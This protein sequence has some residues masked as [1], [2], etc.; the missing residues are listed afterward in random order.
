MKKKT[1]LLLI[2]GMILI[3]FLAIFKEKDIMPN[4]SSPSSN[5]FKKKDSNKETPI[6]KKIKK[7][8]MNDSVINSDMIF[9]IVS[10]NLSKELQQ[11][12]K[13]D[14]ATYVINEANV[15]ENKKFLDENNYLQVEMTIE[16]K[17]N[18]SKD[19]YL[20]NYQVLSE[21]GELRL[22]ASLTSTKTDADPQS[23]SNF[24]FTLA[25]KEKVHIY[26][27]YIITDDQVA[28]YKDKLYIS[29]NTSGG[30][31]Q[32]MD[33]DKKEIKLKINEG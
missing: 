24:S 3:I 23:K 2:V 4:V 17:L 11:L 14:E 16:N 32:A 15:D 1:F 13:V 27:G 25:P 12:P 29:L 6:E 20:N 30:D 18:E 7:N 5:S 9:T 10:A 26:L 28:K 31:F 33:K 19:F 8:N 21:I 22:D